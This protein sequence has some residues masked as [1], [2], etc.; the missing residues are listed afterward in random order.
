MPKLTKDVK[1]SINQQFSQVAANY[2]TSTVH[3]QGSDLQTMVS[4]VP[5]EGTEV[6]LDAGCGAGH[7]TVAF[8]PH[9]K[10]VVAVDLSAAMLDECRRLAQERAVTNVAFEMGDVEKL[11]FA[12]QS[13]DLVVSRYSA[14]H[15]PDPGHAITEFGRILKPGGQLILSDIVSFEEFVVDS[16]VQTIEVLRDPSH[17]RDH[18]IQQWK[19]L[20]EAA[21]FHFQLVSE[22]EVWLNFDSW[23]QRMAT[24]AVNVAGLKSVFESAPEEV[25]HKLKVEEDYSFTFRGAV[26]RGS[27]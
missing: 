12:A 8:A 3:A 26:L 5:F 2:S 11:R 16:Y 15:W 6:V 17:V 10:T 23:V 22:H 24:P 19:T 14:H 20:L 27:L 25:R 21:G 7:T 1:T 9:V 13:F 18:T 4:C